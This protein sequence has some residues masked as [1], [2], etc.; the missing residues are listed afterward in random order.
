MKP[1]FAELRLGKSAGRDL[2]GGGLNSQNN[3]AAV[4]IRLLRASCLAPFAHVDEEYMW[5]QNDELCQWIAS[6]ISDPLSPV[7]VS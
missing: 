1:A 6:I 4:R 3:V 2:I 7:V 5:V